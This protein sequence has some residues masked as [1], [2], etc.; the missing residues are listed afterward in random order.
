MDMTT[1]IG[2]CK[3]LCF[4]YKCL[5]YRSRHDKVDFLI[6][7]SFGIIFKERF[8]LSSQRKERGFSLVGE[9]FI[10]TTGRTFEMNLQIR[11][12]VAYGILFGTL[13]RNPCFSV[14]VLEYL[15]S[16]VFE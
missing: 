12:S 3:N 13:L 10:D 4:I 8:P 7:S 14:T 11:K 15:G 1:W 16:K 9:N 2:K 5:N 6:Q